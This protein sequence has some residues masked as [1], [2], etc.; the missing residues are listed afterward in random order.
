MNEEQ[1]I[2]SKD[3]LE[4]LKKK[5]EAGVNA[6]DIDANMAELFDVLAA[7]FNRFYE[8][9]ESGVLKDFIDFFREEVS[10]NDMKSNEPPMVFADTAKEITCVNGRTVIYP[11]TTVRLCAL[12][13]VGDLAVTTR[14]NM[15]QEYVARVSVTSLTNYREKM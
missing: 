14:L 10:E 2:S 13:P 1:I 6:E 3:E 15:P 5:V 11:R 8:N 12:T 7:D 4:E 9:L